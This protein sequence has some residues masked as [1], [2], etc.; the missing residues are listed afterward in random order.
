MVGWT[1]KWIDTRT[2]RWMG[3]QT[4]GQTDT[5]LD[6]QTDGQTDGH[7]RWSDICE[8]GLMDTRTDGGQLDGH[9]DGQMDTH[10]R[11]DKATLMDG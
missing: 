6:T 5:W 11:M 9:M 3:R 10:R 2:D 4:R 7:K 8:N 1:D